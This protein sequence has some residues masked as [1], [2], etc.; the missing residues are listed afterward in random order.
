MDKVENLLISLI[1]DESIKAR[2]DQV[3]QYVE[4]DR[5]ATSSSKPRYQALDKWKSELDRAGASVHGK[6]AGGAASGSVRA[7]ADLS[8]AWA[9][10]WAVWQ[11]ALVRRS[12]RVLV[13]RASSSVLV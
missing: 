8:C 11:L 13:R 3:G 10:A 2:I 5:S 4:L 1:L 9:S 12:D 7:S 6:H